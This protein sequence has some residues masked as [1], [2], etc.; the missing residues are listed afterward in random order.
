VLA[1]GDDVVEDELKETSW[2]R[3]VSDHGLLILITCVL[4]ARQ[5]LNYSMIAACDEALE[6]LSAASRAKSV[7][8]HFRLECRRTR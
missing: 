2:P 6:M 4:K 8:L 3:P 7:Q 1:L 5:R